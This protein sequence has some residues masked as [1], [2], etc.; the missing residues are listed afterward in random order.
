MR[1]YG[2]DTKPEKPSC[3][4]RG[5]K[6]ISL[7]TTNLQLLDMSQYLAAGSSYEGFVRAYAPHVEDVKCPFPYKWLDS[8]A[9][10]DQ[11]LPPRN[12][13]YNDL[14]NEEL[15]EEDYTDVQE[16]WRTKEFSSMGEYLKYYN[17]LDVDGFVPAVAEYKKWWMTEN[18]D[19]FKQGTNNV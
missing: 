19:C 15:S 4:K 7:S 8:T 5:N 6:Y 17:K 11:G 3:I 10:L 12:D 18:I 9:K 13:F 2:E 1:N 14:K 16:L